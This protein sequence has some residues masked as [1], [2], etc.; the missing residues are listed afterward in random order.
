MDQ[1]MEKMLLK[2]II[3][4]SGTCRLVECLEICSQRQMVWVSY[5]PITIEI[6]NKKAGEA[7]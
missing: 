6:H 7:L 3:L 1:Q 5:S 2:E 4:L